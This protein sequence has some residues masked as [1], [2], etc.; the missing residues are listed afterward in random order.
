MAARKAAGRFFEDRIIEHWSSAIEERFQLPA[1]EDA[2]QHSGPHG[3]P[4][5]AP[6]DREDQQ[7]GRAFQPDL[8]ALRERGDAFESRGH[9]GMSD[10]MLVQLV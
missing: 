2:G 10:G 5:P 9:F 7:A 8:L 4:A 3:Q 6:Q 1:D